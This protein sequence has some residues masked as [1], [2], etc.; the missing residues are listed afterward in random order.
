[1][2]PG[3]DWQRPD[4]SENLAGQPALIPQL[5]LQPAAQRLYSKV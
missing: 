3:P 4:S 5:Q 2:F 1:M